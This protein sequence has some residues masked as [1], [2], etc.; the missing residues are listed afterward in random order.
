[1]LVPVSTTSC[2][3]INNGAW[4]EFQI[5]LHHL[6]HDTRPGGHLWWRRFG[7]SY[8]C[9]RCRQNTDGTLQIAPLCLFVLHCIYVALYS[10]WASD[11]E[12]RL[13]LLDNWQILAL[14]MSH[15][16]KSRIVIQQIVVPSINLVWS[17]R[18]TQP[19][20]TWW[21]HVVKL[22]FHNGTTIRQLNSSSGILPQKTL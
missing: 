3:T 15:A 17:N 13:T 8:F 11:T 7:A 4:C 14:D 22:L 1:M 5:W 6:V 18:T 16:G 20:R 21:E 9:G 12:C 10:F 2:L 19:A